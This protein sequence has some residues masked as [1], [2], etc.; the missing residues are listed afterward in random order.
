M[1]NGTILSAF[2]IAIMTAVSLFFM[3][4]L[5]RLMN[6]PENIFQDAHTYISI[7]CIGI[8]ANV[9]YNLF[10]SFLRAVGNSRVPLLFLAFSS[11][12][13]LVLNLLFVIVFSNGSFRV[14]L[15]HQCV[16]GNICGTLYF[17]YL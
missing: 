8:V 3:K 5:L 14:G 2:V 10:S 1:A 17:V 13:N 9:F 16:P 4:P 6:T 15:G 12:L 11:G 7:I